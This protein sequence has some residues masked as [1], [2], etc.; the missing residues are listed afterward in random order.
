MKKLSDKMQSIVDLLRRRGSAGATS[1]EI[2]LQCHTVAAS[3]RISEL[4]QKGYRIES[5]RLGTSEAGASVWKYVLVESSAPVETQAH[6]PLFEE[7]RRDPQKD[8]AQ[9]ELW[10]PGDQRGF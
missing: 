1:L 10:K 4:R 8:E 7:H 2:A 9:T 3:T 6:P 5:A